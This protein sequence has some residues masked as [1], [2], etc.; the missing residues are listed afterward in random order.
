MEK[1]EAF[2]KAPWISA[3][4]VVIANREDA[5]KRATTLNP[6]LPVVFTDGSAQ[7]DRLGIGVHWGGSL[8]W[9]EVSRTISTP[10]T[11]DSHEAE[12]VAIDCAVP[13]LLRS[14]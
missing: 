5:V 12:L 6:S 10:K 7:N 9:P 3:V 4:P 1:I 14:I 2:S 8:R 13:Q 11:L